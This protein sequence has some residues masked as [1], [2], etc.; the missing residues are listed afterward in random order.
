MI[1]N[2]LPVASVMRALKRSF[3]DG[4]ILCL[5]STAYRSQLSIVI[6]PAAKRAELWL[7]NPWCL[8]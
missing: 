4:R 1:P 8:W 2:P 6:I 7:T 5:H 3:H